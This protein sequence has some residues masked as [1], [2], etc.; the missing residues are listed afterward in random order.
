MDQGKEVGKVMFNKYNLG[1][2][3]FTYL[4]NEL[5]QRMLKIGDHKVRIDVHPELADRLH[6]YVSDL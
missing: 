1:V 4:E 3:L 5:D 2:G 6:N